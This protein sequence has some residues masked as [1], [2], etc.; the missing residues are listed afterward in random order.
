MKDKKYCKV[1]DHCHDTRECRGAARSL[2]NLNFSVPKKIP[3]AFHNGSN[4]DY[5]FIIKELAEKFEKKFACLRENTE[6]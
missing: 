1:R 2:C 3:I 6:K 5:H 4:H